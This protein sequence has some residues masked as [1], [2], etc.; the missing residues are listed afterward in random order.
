MVDSRLWSL[1]RSV[2]RMAWHRRRGTISRL[3]RPWWL[4]GRS[5][6]TL[7]RS[8][9]GPTTSA[10]T[11]HADALAH[12]TEIGHKTYWED[13]CAPLATWHSNPWVAKTFGLVRGAPNPGAESL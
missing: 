13:L 5:H 3:R 1:R 10:S 8:T 9:A 7:P 6:S 2:I 12:Q 11:R 4:T